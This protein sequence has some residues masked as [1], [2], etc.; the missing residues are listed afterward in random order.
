MDRRRW[1]SFLT[2]A[3]V[4][5]E[6]AG[7]DGIMPTAAHAGEEDLGRVAHAGDDTAPIVNN[8]PNI[9]VA[10]AT[11]GPEPITYQHAATMPAYAPTALSSE[12]GEAKI[13]PTV[14][15]LAHSQGAA[16]GGGYGSSVDGMNAGEA[17]GTHIGLAG[18]PF[19]AFNLAGQPLDLGLHIDLS[20]TTY[21]LL[22]GLADSLGNLPLVGAGLNDV[23]SSLAITTSNLVASAEPVVSLLGLHGDASGASTSDVGSPGALSFAGSASPAGGDELATPSGGYTDYGITL[24]LGAFDVAHATGEA[25]VHADSLGSMFDSAPLDTHLGGESDALH[26]DQSVLR[27]ASDILA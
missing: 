13:A 14:D 2:W 22:G 21:G 5:A 16:A 19:S 18:E 26:L 17:D 9:S 12:L 1:T 25:A 10:T 8:L 7:R 24:N 11:E 20:D 3:F 23:G 27:T 4:L 6:M 15:V